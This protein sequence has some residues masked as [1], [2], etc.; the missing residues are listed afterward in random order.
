M[1]LATRLRQ[2][3]GTEWP[4]AEPEHESA[5]QSEDVRA[6]VVVDGAEVPV[7]SE[8]HRVDVEAAR[9]LEQ[10]QD[11]LAGG[12][13]HARRDGRPGL[14]AARARHVDRAREVRAGRRLEMDLAGGRARGG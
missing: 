9:L 4:R 5:D 12:Q 6:R 3:I 8:G 13:R 11:L 2:S 1:S 10:L 7:N 14:P